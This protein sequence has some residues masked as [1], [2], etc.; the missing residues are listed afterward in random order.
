MCSSNDDVLDLQT[1]EYHETKRKLEKDER[2]WRTRPS[3]LMKTQRPEKLHPQLI[4]INLQPRIPVTNLTAR[5]AS[6]DVCW[7]HQHRSET[8]KHAVILLSQIKGSAQIAGV[9]N[10]FVSANLSLRMQ[11]RLE[12]VLLRNAAA[13][14]NLT[15]HKALLRDEQLKLGCESSDTNTHNPCIHCS[16]GFTW[17]ISLCRK[18]ITGTGSDG[19]HPCVRDAGNVINSSSSVSLNLPHVSLTAVTF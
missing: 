10:A 15:T 11:M 13:G 9:L 19:T 7:H 5:W 1:P 18:R 4:L 3:L 6:G 17:L 2:K 16:C 8:Q 12:R 14:H